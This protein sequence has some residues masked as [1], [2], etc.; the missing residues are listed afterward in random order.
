MVAEAIEYGMTA[1]RKSSDAW[2]TRSVV[3]GE[4]KGGKF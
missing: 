1:M 3:S 2:N 4:G